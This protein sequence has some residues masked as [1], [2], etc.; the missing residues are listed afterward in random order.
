MAEKAAGRIELRLGVAQHPALATFAGKDPV[1]ELVW[2]LVGDRL[3]PR[4]QDQ[5]AML[6][7]N[8][9]GPALAPRPGPRQSGAQI[10]PHTGIHTAAIWPGP[11]ASPRTPEQ[12]PA[13]TQSSNRR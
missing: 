5:G 13:C 6:G 8:V 9:S 1:L 4:R 3:F 10:H 12:R 7:M 11:K 2:R